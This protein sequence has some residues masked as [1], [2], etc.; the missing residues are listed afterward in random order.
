MFP[1]QMYKCRAHL[2]GIVWLYFIPITASYLHDMI[3]CILLGFIVVFLL[4]QAV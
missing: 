3:Q 4:T 1:G 2:N